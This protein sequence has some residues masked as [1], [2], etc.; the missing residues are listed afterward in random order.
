MTATARYDGSSRFGT[1]NKWGFFPSVG[2]GWRISEETFLANNKVITNLKLRGSYGITG[3]QEIGNYKSLAQLKSK[4]YI[5]NDALMQGFYETI[6]NPDLKWERTKQFDLGF[7]LSLWNRIHLNVDYYSRRTSDLLYDV[8]IPSTSG[9]STMLSNIGIVSNKGVEIALSGRIVETKD[10][11][12]DAT[13]NISKNKNEI[14]EL[15]NDVESI[16]VTSGLGLSKYL[17]VGESL[18]SIYGLKSEGII[19][20]EEQLAAY[21]KIVP[22]AN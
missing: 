19:K 20:T 8:P 9:F 11:K 14:K 2:L 16:T 3:N 17:K 22:T 10:F 1:N 15:Y 13:V 6:G 12:L 21:Q 18:L 5:Y 7:D 4:N